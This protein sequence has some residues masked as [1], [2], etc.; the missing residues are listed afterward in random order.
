MRLNKP[1]RFLIQFSLGPLSPI[2][3]NQPGSPPEGKLPSMS[4]SSGS[5][6][7]VQ[8]PSAKIAITSNLDWQSNLPTVDILRL[9]SLSYLI[10]NYNVLVQGWASM[11]PEEVFTRV[12]SSRI[13]WEENGACMFHMAVFISPGPYFKIK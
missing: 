13:P 7:C 8:I 9:L 6:F 4:L 2:I 12:C 3:Y 10:L 1:A 5:A 11:D